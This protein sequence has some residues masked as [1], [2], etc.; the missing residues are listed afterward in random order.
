MWADLSHLALDNQTVGL[1]GG[2]FNPAHAGHLH[3][4]LEALKRLK[5]D[6]ILWLV[7]PQNPLK[8]K[9]ELADYQSR[10]K[11]AKAITRNH[12]QIIVSDLESVIESDYSLETIRYMLSHY[13]RSR[14]VWL[15]GAD[16][17]QH[18]H[19]WHR[20]QEITQLI[21]MAIFDRA[22]FSH[23]ALRAPAALTYQKQR[24]KPS[25]LPKLAQTLPPA[26]SYV[27]MQ[28]HGESATNLR[29][30]LGK[31]AFMVHN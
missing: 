8:S 20:W 12:P 17:L 11:M 29:K 6:R 14:F 5:L 1:L 10:L 15:M 21:P 16:N 27:F 19:R 3:L 22:P 13:P 28:R 18:M 26:W 31:S 25:A 4:S 30:T 9:S 23:A 7:S 2:S 24:L